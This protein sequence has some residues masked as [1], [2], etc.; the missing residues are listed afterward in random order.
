MEVNVG[1]NNSLENNFVKFIDDITNT[2][3][4][5]DKLVN[6]CRE[7]GYEVHCLDNDKGY[8]K[9]L[10]GFRLEL[11]SRFVDKSIEHEQDCMLRSYIKAIA[12]PDNFVFHKIKTA[13][14]LNDN[15]VD[16]KNELTN[17]LVETVF[18]DIYSNSK[19]IH[20]MSMQSLLSQER[21]VSL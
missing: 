21:K 18:K 9:I 7:K 3:K 14:T 11:R 6:Y 10:S 12:L 2:S 5:E 4:L 17:Y 20:M 8:G 16:I 1:R 13:V 15:L 19:K